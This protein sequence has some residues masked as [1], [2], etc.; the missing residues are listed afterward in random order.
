MFNVS[1]TTLPDI[2][3][4]LEV[5]RARAAQGLPTPG[6][7]TEI[8]NQV[9]AAAT[10]ELVAL[11]NNSLV[12]TLTSG[13]IL[14]EWVAIFQGV[15]NGTLNRTFSL[16]AAHDTTVAPMVLALQMPLKVWPNYAS[17]LYLGLLRSSSGDYF[18]ETIHDGLPARMAGCS[19]NPCPWAEFLAVA[20]QSFVADRAAA[21]GVSSRQRS[22]KLFDPVAAFLC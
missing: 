2:F 16:F 15:M 13:Q 9:Q 11:Y 21:C 7:T 6:L 14:A 8:Y 20:S 4:V 10:W 22:V 12:H 17:N 3:L 19:A 1:L 18:V 5:L